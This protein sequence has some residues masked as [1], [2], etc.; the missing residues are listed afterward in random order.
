MPGVSARLGTRLCAFYRVTEQKRR[1]IN[2]TS[3]S[4]TI[5]AVALSSRE[6]ALLICLWCESLNAAISNKQCTAELQ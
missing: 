4:L 3:N 2:Q 1:D 5:Q 6:S